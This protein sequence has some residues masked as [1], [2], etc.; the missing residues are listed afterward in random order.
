[1]IP[2]L[3]LD[4]N[5]AR[6]FDTACNGDDDDR[7]IGTP[8]KV[9]WVF[10]R[11]T[12]ISSLLI[13]NRDKN[14]R[15]QN[16]NNNKCNETAHC[17]DGMH[18]MHSVSICVCCCCYAFFAVVV[19]VALLVFHLFLSF[20][21]SLSRFLANICESILLR[22]TCRARCLW[23][24]FMVTLNSLQNHNS[25]SFGTGAV[26]HFY[27]LFAILLLVC[28]HLVYLFCLCVIPL[29]PFSFHFGRCAKKKDRWIGLLLCC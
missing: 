15:K 18:V 29:M 12:H 19:V 3:L 28:C 13:S 16:N 22:K 5:F 25:I 17:D 24:S 1:M 2:I 21:L 4:L 27:L 20:S 26:L 14:V 11:H 9:I 8:K 23:F 10:T 6:Q 7:F